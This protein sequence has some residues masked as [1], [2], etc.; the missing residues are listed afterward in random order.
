MENKPE[1]VEVIVGDEARGRLAEGGGT[2]GHVDLGA[3][4]LLATLTEF[5]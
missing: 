4:G 3:A 2:W 1:K 5:Y